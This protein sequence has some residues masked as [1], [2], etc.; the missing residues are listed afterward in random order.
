LIT[1]SNSVDINNANFILN[2]QKNAIKFNSLFLQKLEKGIFSFNLKKYEESYNY[3]L[4]TGIVKS[5]EEFAELL[6]II[7]GFDKYIIGEFLAKEKYPNKEHKILKAYMSKIDFSKMGFLD[8]IRFFL[9]RVNLPKDSV[10]ILTI[11]N[12]FSEAIYR[13][14]KN[15]Y[16]DTNSIYLLAS[17][18][19]AINT[20][21]HRGIENVKMMKKEEFVAMNKDVNK[22]LAESIYEEVK[23]KK[24]DMV[25]DYNELIYR[26]LTV[27]ANHISDKEIITDN[28]I[29][30]E[31]KRDDLLTPIKEGTVFTKYGEYG[32]PHSRMVKLSQDEKRLIWYPIDGCGIFK[33]TKSLEV[34]EI[35][36]VYIGSSASKIFQKYN[37]PLDFDSHCFSIV[38]SRRSLDLRKDD[39][40]VCKK[41]YQAIKFLI[42]RTR[43]VKELKNNK[44]YLKDV[45]NKNE[46]VSE[47]W[48][49]EILPNWHIY[50]TFVI[51][52]GRKIYD[53]SSSESKKNKEK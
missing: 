24:L 47:I 15:L 18:V 46:I 3:L 14:N 6:L 12:E 53:F 42:R 36:D 48:K 1:V 33:S 20:I 51:S 10:Y 11:I 25:H 9:S 16:K 50:R 17:T 26:R 19:L 29:P 4:G 8:S 41:W 22:H 2:D 39:E 28:S 32:K 43:S 49:T 38:S 31:I 40:A 5:E 37:I 34:S 44:N 35:L 45:S 7:Q 30:N 27:K 52:R 13:D 21:F 23:I